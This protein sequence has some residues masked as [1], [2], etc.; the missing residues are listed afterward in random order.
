M[1]TFSALLAICAGNSP[2]PGEFPTQRPVTRS[3]DVYFNLRPN[4]RL[5]KQRE[6]GDLRR[7]RVH[8]DVV[9]MVDVLVPYLIRPS[10]TNT[11]N[12]QELVLDFNK[13]GSKPP[14]P[15]RSFLELENA[16]AS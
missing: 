15:Y 9:V 8:Y 1:E 3:L 11:V 16:D 5:S 12:M 4:K 7:N 13:D 6:A 2:V 10:L 14:A